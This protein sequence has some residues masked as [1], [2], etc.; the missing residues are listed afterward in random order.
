MIEEWPNGF[1]DR[2][3]S[4]AKSALPSLAVRPRRPIREGNSPACPLREALRRTR[5]APKRTSRT[6]PSR[7]G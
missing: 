5:T 7:A 6:A 1:P 2:L 3:L 4:S